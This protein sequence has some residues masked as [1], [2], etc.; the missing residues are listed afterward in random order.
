MEKVKLIKYK[1][2]PQLS[3]IYQVIQ[4]Q[5]AFTTESKPKV[6][7]QETPFVLC[8]DFLHDAVRAYATNNPCSI[9]G[10]VFHPEYNSIDLKR[11][12]ILVKFSGLDN[13]IDKIIHLLHLFEKRMRI[14]RTVA[15]GTQEKDIFLLKGSKS[16]QAS[17]QFISLYTLLMRVAVSLNCKVSQDIES[18]NTFGAL[19]RQWRNNK[20]SANIGGNDV[21]YLPHLGKYL[22]TVISNRSKL[23]LT[24]D[25]SI[26]GDKRGISNY[27]NSSGIMSL[28]SK[29]LARNTG[30]SDRR[31]YQL[32]DLYTKRKKGRQKVVGK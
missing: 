29:E 16:W 23:G 20:Y 7:K 30:L 25:K 26:K 14:K 17:P 3:E 21:G 32:N 28:C 11:T 8:R 6:Y 4:M 13:Y 1:G 19:M 31:H 27:H 24:F 5:F 12:L 18:A 2:T 10:F 22:Q 15:Y 9:Y